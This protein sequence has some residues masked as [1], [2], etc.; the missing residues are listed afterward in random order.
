[1]KRHLFLLFIL[2]QACS[3]EYHRA[4]YRAP[5]DYRS[6]SDCYINADSTQYLGATCPRQRWYLKKNDR[7]IWTEISYGDSLK[8]DSA[9]GNDGRLRWVRQMIYAPKNPSYLCD[10]IVNDHFDKQARPLYR[11]TS[12][13]T[14][15]TNYDFKQ[16]YDKHG[17]LEPDSLPVYYELQAL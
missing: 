13:Y 11:H 9:F 1:M 4:H 14:P 10:K 6:V 7:H 5:I 16:W 8:L 3:W 15:D 17:K 2:N 12:I